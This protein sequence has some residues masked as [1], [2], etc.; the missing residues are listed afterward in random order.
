MLV[1]DI[2]TLRAQAWP[3]L[4]RAYDLAAGRAN[5]PPLLAGI[6]DGGSVQVRAATGDGR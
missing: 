5:P 6:S 3:E 1:H 2:Q 4:Q